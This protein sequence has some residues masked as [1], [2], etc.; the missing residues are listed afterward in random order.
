MIITIP[1]TITIPDTIDIPDWM[2]YMGAAFLALV[3]ACKVLIWMGDLAN[4]ILSGGIG[5]K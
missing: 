1:K 3:I 2:L 4:T 5:K